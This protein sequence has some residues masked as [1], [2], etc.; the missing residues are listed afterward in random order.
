M[1]ARPAAGEVLVV[2]VTTPHSCRR[3]LGAILA[4]L[5][6]H[7]AAHKFPLATAKRKCCGWPPKTGFDPEQTLAEVAKWHLVIVFLFNALG[8][9]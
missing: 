5:R 7:A 2:L 3:P 9:L 6:Q 1:E 4:R 8:V